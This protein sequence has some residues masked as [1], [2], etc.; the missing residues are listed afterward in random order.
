MVQT[1]L[2]KLTSQD[3]TEIERYLSSNTEEYLLEYVEFSPKDF[4]HETLDHL[5]NSTTEKEAT[6]KV[7]G[8]YAPKR[9]LSFTMLLLYVVI[10]GFYIVKSPLGLVVSLSLALV[11]VDVLSSVLKRQVEDSD[12]TSWV[13]SKISSFAKPYS[14]YI[15]LLSGYLALAVVAL[16]VAVKG[17]IFLWSVYSD[18]G[19]DGLQSPSS[20]LVVLY[21]LFALLRVFYFPNEFFAEMKKF[22]LLMQYRAYMA[23]MLNW[24]LINKLAQYQVEI[25]PSD[26]EPLWFSTF[27]KFYGDRDG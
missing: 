19:F 3:L 23:V 15:L 1:S 26:L 6:L 20:L 5:R 21:V 25:K 27:A 9:L 12:L 16:M 14:K 10:M 24:L 4:L 18:K 7:L 22:E 11:S 2:S 17:S 8:N 13:L